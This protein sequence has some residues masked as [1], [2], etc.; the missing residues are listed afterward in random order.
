M[1]K[2]L[3]TIRKRK[4]RLLMSVWLGTGDF[5]A[6]LFSAFLVLVFWSWINPELLLEN[7]RVLIPVPLLFLAIFAIMDLYP[8]IG[9]SPV[10]E[11]RRLV[12]TTSTVFFALGTLSFYLR[13][14]EHWSRAS[15]GLAWMCSLLAL[16][17]TRAV[18]RE[19]G[20][21]LGFWGEDVL[22]FGVGS[23]ADKLYQ[24][25]LRTPKAGM[26]PVGQVD[27]QTFFT[28]DGYPEQLP[29][30]WSM[31]KTAV[32]DGANLS[33]G[34]VL[35]AVEGLWNLFQRII[36]LQDQ[37]RFGVLGMKMYDVGGLSALKI[38][39]NLL[40]PLQ[41]WI[42]RLL[43]D[44][45]V[46]VSSPLWLLVVSVISVVIWIESPGKV[47]YQHERVGKHGKRFGVWKFR[48]MVPEADQLLS[49]YL[50][51]HP[52]AK[53][54]WALRQKLSDDPRVTRVGK[55]LRKLSLDELPQVFNVLRGEMSLVGPRPIIEEEIPNYGRKFRLYQQ[56]LP[57]LTGFWQVSGRNDLDY[58]QRVSLDEYYVRN[59]SIWFDFYIL[60]KTMKVVISGKGAY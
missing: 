36:I 16:P 31:V 7:Y 3:E 18:F 33:E 50:E 34:H 52:E 60:V 54:E 55:L 11:I 1:M 14:V 51:S 53:K 57:G 15:F 4:A 13:D 8:A 49:A 9:L 45:I 46:V 37:V 29:R 58:A 22:V 27:L 30:E 42:K 2:V 44:L 10:E 5:L 43:D 6:I 38:N 48:T 35:P 20:V 17:M 12:L 39:Q 32:I 59:W 41:Q 40:N 25:L 19:I 26:R 47:F 24:H 23:N 56:V 21:R 28:G